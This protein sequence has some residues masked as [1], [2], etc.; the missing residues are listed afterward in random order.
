[1]YNSTGDRCCDGGGGGTQVHES[2]Q[3]GRWSCA[4]RLETSLRSWGTVGP[5][6]RWQDKVAAQQ[7]PQCLEQMPDVWGQTLMG[8]EH[9]RVGFCFYSTSSGKWSV[10]EGVE[11]KGCVTRSVFAE[12][13]AFLGFSVE[14]GLE[15]SPRG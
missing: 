10:I 11:I 5:R 1:M 3:W 15:R 7:R 8:L 2:K 9:Q 4:E 12:K 14:N 13:G 6:G